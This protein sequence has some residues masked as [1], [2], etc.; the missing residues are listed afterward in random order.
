MK[1][2]THPDDESLTRL[3]GEL[4]YTGHNVVDFEQYVLSN[5]IMK[6]DFKGF[7]RAYNWYITHGYLQ[8]KAQR[9]GKQ[10]F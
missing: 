1:W 5:Y 2:F 3:N 10:T 8:P 7:Q 4:I 9:L 6:D